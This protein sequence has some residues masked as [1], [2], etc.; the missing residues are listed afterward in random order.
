[1]LLSKRFLVVISSLITAEVE[2]RSCKGFIALK[3]MELYGGTVTCM[4]GYT[5][6]D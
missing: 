3:D 6:K 4:E 2:L 5:R 1:M